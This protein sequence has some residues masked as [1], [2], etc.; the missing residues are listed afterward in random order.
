MAILE[1]TMQV[2][3]LIVD[4]NARIINYQIRRITT[5]FLSE[6]FGNFK[7]RGR[8]HSRFLDVAAKDGRA[9][10]VFHLLYVENKRINGKTA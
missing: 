7:Q 9:F 6:N 2:F 3:Y 1:F 8:A 4:K 10:Y 5:T